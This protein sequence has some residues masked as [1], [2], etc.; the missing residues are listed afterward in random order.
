M[1]SSPQSSIE[2]ELKLANEAYRAGDLDSAQ[3][4]IDGLLRLNPDRADVHMAK[5]MIVMAKGDQVQ[6]REWLVSSLRI[7][8]DNSEALAWA[9]FISLNM[10]RF[11]EAEG[12][13]RA[14]TRIDP[15][16]ARAHYLLANALR[17]LDR[18]E[19]ALAAID[20]SLAI[21]PDNTDGLVTKARLLKRWQM[22]GL[23]IE[24]YRKAL[25]IRPSPPAAVDLAQ[26][27]LRESHPQ[28]ALDVLRGIERYMPESDRPHALIA[29]AHTEMRQF[30]EAGERWSLAQKFSRDP[31]SLTQSR[32][33][34]EIAVGRFEIAQRL[35]MEAIE[36]GLAVPS[37]FFIL[38]TARKMNR[39]DMPLIGRMESM[40]TAGKLTAPQAAD[41]NYG[42]GKS[43][44]DLKEFERAIGY[45]DEANRISY[46]LHPRRRSFS[47]E[48]AQAYTDFQ[49]AFFTADRIHA[50]SGQG[51]ESTLPLFVVGMIRSG[52]TLTESIL[53]AHSKVKAG[54]E[55]SFWIE[56]AIE[57]LYR[58]SGALQLDHD[59]VMRFA[60]DYVALID[61][62]QEDVR[63]VVDKNPGNFDL[64]AMLHCAYPNAKFIHL[65]RHPVDNLLSMWMTPVSGNVKY[66][67]NRDNLVF[68][69]REYLRLCR[70]LKEVLPEDRFAT[71]RYEDLTSRPEETIPAM[72]AHL[73]LEPEPACFAPEQNPRAVLTPSVHQVRQPIHRASQERWKSYEPWLGSFAEMF[74]ETESA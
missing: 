30:E 34:A 62:K 42:L 24:L 37:S 69:Y 43:F 14:L 26:I 25:A 60:Q 46:E 70:H 41:L 18:V 10:H 67:S 27:L 45:Y 57:F 2:A 71:F 48:E 64:A 53:S 7:E 16:N 22:S 23:A 31:A 11:E 59:L 44:D 68:T 58:D 36:E 33:K 1:Q 39:E 47:R 21:E 54:G 56:R 20:R 9:A 40:L 5:G 3:V 8:P 52:T 4:R 12:F 65:K 17:A 74:E 50:L 73:G 55:Q 32:A 29:Q 13:A 63:Y 51:L 38:T 61:P 6:A 66:A 28:E 15:H 35:L 19:E 49:I 72:L